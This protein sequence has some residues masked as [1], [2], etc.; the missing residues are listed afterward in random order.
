MD[1][2]QEYITITQVARDLGWNK[3]TVYDWIKT[4]GLEKHR[5][6]RNKHT[7]LHSSDV[8]RLKE[9]KE[10]PWTAGPNTART[11]RNVSEKAENP[12][13]L[14]PAKTTKAKVEK[15]EKRDYKDRDTGL[16]EGCILAID[17]ARN[18][19]V[20]RETFRDHMTKGLGP[21]LIGTH[22]D[23]IPQRDQVDYSERDKPGRKGEKEKYLTGD[24]Q[25]AVIQFW[26]RHKVP[27]TECDQD[28]CSCHTL[29]SGE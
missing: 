11:A 6:L 3:A 12:P 21:G 5:F 2:E 19:D 13:V 4:L 24:Q 8:Q 28:G 22:T 1:N 14:P 16:P 9:I 10:K 15:A 29:K 20:K 25:S 7:Y 27:F 17:F 26:Q 23:T 18:H